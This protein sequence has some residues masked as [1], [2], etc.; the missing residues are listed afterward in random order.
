MR[1]SFEAREKISKKLK[2]I[3]KSEETKRK[4][5][6]TK[7]KYSIK[8]DKV[9]INNLI[10]DYESNRMTISDCMK[11]YNLSKSIVTKYLRKNNVHIRTNSESH[12]LPR[13]KELDDKILE[14]YKNGKTMSEVS[15]ILNVKR[16]HVYSV[17]TYNNC[18]RGR[19][20]HDNNPKKRAET[21]R[22]NNSFNS[23]KPEDKMLKELI[24]KY[25]EENVLTQYIEERYPFKCDFYIKS[26]DLFIELNAH[27]SHGFKPYDANDTECQERLKMWQEKAKTSKFYRQ[28]IYVWTDL[29]VR[30]QRCAKENKLNYITIY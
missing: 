23:S 15:K 1:V 7:E 13:N 30:K 4:I 26:K 16:G 14:L 3:P 25:G 22:K 28:A 27:W 11:K 8:L 20:P 18:S 19:Y 17:I 2:G 29:D 12:S 10:Y 6:E 5:K 24:E 21:M 9:T